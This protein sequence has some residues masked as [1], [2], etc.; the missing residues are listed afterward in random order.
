MDTRPHTWRAGLTPAALDTGHIALEERDRAA[1]IAQLAALSG[2]VAYDDGTALRPG[3]WAAMWRDDLVF[4][5]AE[6]CQVDARVEY[7]RHRNDPKGAMAQTLAGALARVQTWRG[8]ARALPGALAGQGIEAALYKTLDDAITTELGPALSERT[9]TPRAS[10]SL[11]ALATAAAWDDKSSATL[12]LAYSTANRATGRLVAV[13]RDYLDRALRE[14]SDHAP[15]VG[16]ALGFLES[17]RMLQADF[18]ALTE[19]HLLYH[20]KS[21]LQLHPAPPVPDRAEVVFDLAPGTRTLTLPKGTRLVGNAPEGAVPLHYD[22][23]R[24]THLSAGTLA[25]RRVVRLRRSRVPTPKDPAATWIRAVHAGVIAGDGPWHPFRAPD[26][27]PVDIGIS[28]RDPSLLMAGGARQVRVHLRFDPHATVS[29]SVALRRFHGQAQ[30]DLGGRV[31]RTDLHRLGRDAFDVRLDGQPMAVDGAAVA[32]GTLTLY[33]SL[34]PEA[35]PVAVPELKLSLSHRAKVYAASAMAGLVLAGVEL[36]VSVTD[37]RPTQATG[38]DLPLDLNAPAPVFGPAP[39]VGAVFA[40]DVGELAGKHV[41]SLALSL[42]WAGLPLDAAQ[43]SDIYAPYDLAGIEDFEGTL[44][45]GN[46]KTAKVLPPEPLFQRKRGG[47]IGKRRTWRVV[48]AGLGHILQLRLTAPEIGFG[49]ARYPAVLTQAATPA[50]RRFEALRAPPA[51]PVLPAQPPVPMAANITVD[52]TAQA[53]V[54]ISAIWRLPMMAD[55]PHGFQ[56]SAKGL[57]LDMPAADALLYLGFDG[58]PEAAP[59]SMLID[60]EPCYAPQW[61][62]DSTHRRPSLNWYFRLKSAWDTLPDEALET[63]LTRGLVVPGVIRMRMPRDAD[64]ARKWVVAAIEGD[65][66]RYGTIKALHMR[67]GLVARVLPEDT[68]P[69]S[70]PN[71]EAQAVAPDPDAPP[72]NVPLGT[73]RALEVPVPGIKTL[74]QPRASDGGHCRETEAAFRTR[75]SGR[76]RHRGRAITARDYERLVLDRFPQV[77]QARLSQVS[78]GHLVLAVTPQRTGRVTGAPPELPMITRYDIHQFLI[79]HCAP[80]VTRLSV[81]APQWEPVEVQAMV[82]PLRDAPASLLGDLEAYVARHIAPWLN[83]PDTPMNIGTGQADADS[84]QALLEAH[85]YVA[86]ADAVGL[87]HAYAQPGVQ[88]DLHGLKDTARGPAGRIACATAW[89]VLVPVRPLALRLLPRR[90]GIG[91]LGV[92]TDLQAFTP[93]DRAIFAATPQ[94]IPLRARPFGIGGLRIG[95]SFVITDPSDA[96]PPKETPL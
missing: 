65:P 50:R 44:A 90:V 13:A 72:A 58:L 28:F 7:A 8:R 93:D 14:K 9:Q 66:D 23:V 38:A 32:A 31:G 49:H 88:G 87:L 94:R 11:S 52:Y 24:D 33:L 27:A 56:P 26:M 34:P 64:G 21:V 89:S 61:T 20:Y 2:H 57:R 45:H 59:L 92:R 29:L 47:Q 1:M 76:L 60:I 6:M 30:R 22:L 51:P 39:K 67:A 55:I 85:P 71:E 80:S 48:G 16:L 75:V 53:T 25:A 5:L 46:G 68:A 4:L 73:I 15:H 40:I 79:Q 70:E 81:R 12:S 95:A 17:Y 54:P 3:G 83:D 62:A 18:A 41:T 63:D 69:A 91:D 42:D 82:Q 35:P 74:S 86:R 37:L 96:I 84:V 36:E 43:W 10:F 78:P 77:G 19:R